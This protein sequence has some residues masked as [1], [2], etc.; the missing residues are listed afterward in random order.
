MKYIPKLHKRKCTDLKTECIIV[1]N[2]RI[3]TVN[4]F[5]PVCR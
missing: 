2:L 4:L 5:L 1:V 3:F